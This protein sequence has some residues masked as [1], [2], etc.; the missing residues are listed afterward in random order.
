MLIPIVILILIIIVH[1]VQLT[2]DF[3]PFNTYFDLGI[4]I[5]PVGTV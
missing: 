4:W 2:S 5:W 1:S 3:S